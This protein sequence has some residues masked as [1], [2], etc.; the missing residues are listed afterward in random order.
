MELDV[1]QKDKEGLSPV[2]LAEK[3]GHRKCADY[4]KIAVSKVHFVFITTLHDS[5]IV[6]RVFPTHLL[7]VLNIYTSQRKN[8]I[9]LLSHKGNFS[10]N[11]ARSNSLQATT[12]SC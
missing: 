7:H 1:Q 10:Q 2:A 4:L 11:S 9:R 6:T 5:M 3:K 8:L 12:S